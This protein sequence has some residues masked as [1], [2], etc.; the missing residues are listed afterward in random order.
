MENARLPLYSLDDAPMDSENPARVLWLLASLC[1][2]AC[3]EQMTGSPAESPQSSDPE[4]VPGYSARAFY[5]T[6]SYDLV[7]SEGRAFSAEWPFTA[8][9]FGSDRRLQRLVDAARRDVA[10]AVDGL[11]RQRDLRRQLVPRR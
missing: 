4:S 7:P 8:H 11:R 1:H 3:G 2:A 9:F 10:A 5:E 6:T